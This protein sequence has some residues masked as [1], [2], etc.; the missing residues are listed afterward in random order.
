MDDQN[1][2]DLPFIQY[3]FSLNCKVKKN[4]EM[5]N[6]LQSLLTTILL[7]FFHFGALAT[8]WD[9]FQKTDAES[10]KSFLT[11]DSYLVCKWKNSLLRKKRA[12]GSYLSRI[13]KYSKNY[14]IELGEDQ[15]SFCSRISATATELSSQI[16]SVEGGLLETIKKF[17]IKDRDRL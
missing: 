11:T 3:Y 7:I 5:P 14:A 12:D 2:N 1:P 8:G 13:V 17:T 9:D 10:L 15:S 4:P 16:P 6:R